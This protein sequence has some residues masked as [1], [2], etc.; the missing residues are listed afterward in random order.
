V[1]SYPR[2]GFGHFFFS[3]Y[4]DVTIPCV[5]LADSLPRV[6][7]WGGEDSQD[8]STLVSKPQL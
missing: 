2:S 1:L 5:S 8:V 3:A 7:V 4:S 6:V